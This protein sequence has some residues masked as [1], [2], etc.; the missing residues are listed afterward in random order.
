M[1]VIK[2]FMMLRLFVRLLRSAERRDVLRS[3]HEMCCLFLLCGVEEQ[4]NGLKVESLCLH[5]VLLFMFTFFCCCWEKNADSSAFI[6]LKCLVTRLL[7]R[8]SS[9]SCVVYRLCVCVCELLTDRF[10]TADSDL[11]RSQTAPVTVLRRKP[12]SLTQIFKS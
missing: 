5:T 7:R 9:N 12:G 10:S 1:K 11:S 4:R 6:N 8:F 3:C 2:C